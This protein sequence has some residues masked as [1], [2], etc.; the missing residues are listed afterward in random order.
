MSNS[1]SEENAVNAAVLELTTCLELVQSAD[2]TYATC[3]MNTGLFELVPV[4][5][6]SERGEQEA[7]ANRT[8]LFESQLAPATALGT[9]R[10]MCSAPT[11]VASPSCCKATAKLHACELTPALV[12]EQLTSCKRAFDRGFQFTHECSGV[13][14]GDVGL[15]VST[16][17]VL[18]AVFAVAM[19]ARQHL[20]GYSRQ[21]QRVANT[22]DSVLELRLARSPSWKALLA[23][24]RQISNLV[25]KN[26]LIKQRKPVA[27]VV[28]QFLPVLLSI[29]L[30]LLANLDS[31][32]GSV[33]SPS[34]SATTRTYQA[35]TNETEIFCMNYTVSDLADL[36]GPNS[37]MSAFYASG[38]AVLGM[39]FLVTYIKFVSSTTTAM[40][41]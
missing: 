8:A 17:L 9:C 40:V 5:P 3:V 33:G 21:L 22:S 34:S 38:Q 7:L 10:L 4:P 2:L 11:T 23:A 25:W 27:L 14:S 32:F 20:N 39:F 18:A 12:T 35:S 24:W 37:T 6:P 29:G 1:T 13:S 15:V 16:A 41:L 36:G 28:E 31:L 19:S 26:L 30:V